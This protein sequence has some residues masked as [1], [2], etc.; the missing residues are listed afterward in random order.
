MQ[1]V[2][3]ARMVSSTMAVLA[4]DHLHQALDQGPLSHTGVVGFLPCLLHAWSLESAILYSTYCLYVTPAKCLLLFSFFCKSMSVFVQEKVESRA[5]LSGWLL[6]VF[7]SPQMA[8]DPMPMVDNAPLVRDHAAEFHGLAAWP[9]QPKL[10]PTVI[11]CECPACQ[12][13]VGSLEQ[14]WQQILR[15]LPRLSVYAWIVVRICL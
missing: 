6:D 4:L 14:M 1:S 11:L 10:V 13:S 8:M 15:S 3:V 12:S 2:L 5:H 9:A 7:C